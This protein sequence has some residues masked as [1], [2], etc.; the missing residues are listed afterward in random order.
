LLVVNALL[1]IVVPTAIYLIVL[2]LLDPYE[3]EPLS[4]LGVMLLAGAI[5]A[6]LL[7]RLVE[8]VFGLPN[9][10]YPG[11]F[12]IYQSLSG[13]PPNIWTGVVEEAAKGAV[14][15]AVFVFMQ[16]EFDD[17][18]DGFVYGAVVG[19]GFALAESLVY[20]KDL[21]AVGQV[22]QASG[23]YFLAVFFSGL[24]QCFF[25]GIFGASLGYMREADPG[26]WAIGLG[27]FFAAAVYHMAYI[28][29]A[30]V[31]STPGAGPAAALAGVG[32]VVVNWLGI[33]LVFVMLRWAWGRERHIFSQTLP[34]EVATGAVTGDELA[35]L[36]AGHRIGRQFA[37]LRREGW[38]HYKAVR[39]LHQAQ[40]ELAFAKWR[41]L[42]GVGSEEE[43]KRAREEI[44]RLRE[45][46]R[47]G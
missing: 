28:G 31:A 43:V 5:V 15:L 36:A 6:P 26:D 29:L 9:S 45:S 44:R 38:A 30:S 17:T 12:Q 41:I 3:R 22:A 18:L 32:R 19:A 47:R 23:G 1:L 21:L 4:D 34:G 33:V 35:F 16:R 37:A 46:G 11:L 40:A 2:W 24:S 8:A 13:T 7:T 10:V 42:R 25:T 39:R 14:V 27:G 20:V